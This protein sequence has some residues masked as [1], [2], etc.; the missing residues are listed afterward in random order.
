MNIETSRQNTKG[1]LA[2][3]L[4]QGE[5]ETERLRHGARGNGVSETHDAVG[6]SI[7]NG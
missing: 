7:S 4:S 3:Y 6:R 2:L 5:G 1:D